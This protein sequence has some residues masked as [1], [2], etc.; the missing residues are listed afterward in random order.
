[1]SLDTSAL[2]NF[3]DRLDKELAKKITLVAVGGTAMTLLNLKS[4]TIDID[5]TIPSNDRPAY[6]KAEQSIQHGL[7]I[8]VCEDGY[9]FCQGLPSDY[10]E[11]SSNIKEYD[12]IVLK[13]LNPID[14]VV[15]KIGR[16]NE[17]D[18]Q[19]IEWCIKG[20]NLSKKQILDRARDIEYAGDEELYKYNLN[21][22]LNNFFNNI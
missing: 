10:L 22:V 7:K 15:T 16:L 1:M 21:W 11:K 14:I 3:L 18:V 20:C 4:S 9:V 5:F 2:L 13:A 19:D 17:R 6:D 12:H 8:D